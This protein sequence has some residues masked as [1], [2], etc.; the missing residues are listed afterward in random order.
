MRCV[1]SSES[2]WLVVKDPKNLQKRPLMATKTIEIV[3]A[4]AEVKGIQETVGETL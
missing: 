4:D 3:V 1:F 2:A